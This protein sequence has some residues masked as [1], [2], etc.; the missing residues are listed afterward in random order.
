MN[1]MNDVM[2]AASWFGFTRGLIIVL[3]VASAAL[4]MGIILLQK[5]RGGGLSS[6]FGGAMG[7]SPFG[8][9]TGD[10]FTWIT[11]VLAGVFLL[12]ALVLNRMVTKESAHTGT[13]TK[14]VA[15]ATPSPTAKPDIES[16]IPI[17]SP[18]S[19]T[20]PETQPGR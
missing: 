17:P 5:G 4:L 18:A 9:K 10:V 7:A 1:V 3:F 8:T 2:L 16:V 12:G 14:A 13:S 11:V 15:K 19:T 20:R 6:A